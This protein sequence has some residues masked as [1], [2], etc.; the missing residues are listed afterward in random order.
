MAASIETRGKTSTHLSHYIGSGRQIITSEL[1][2][3]RDLLRYATD[4]SLGRGTLDK[5]EKF[6]EGLDQLF[7]ILHCKC[8]IVLCSEYGCNNPEC[9]QKVHIN[10]NCARDQ[11]IPVIELM[12]IKAQKAK[13]GSI[14]IHMIANKDVPETRR[15]EA[16]LQRQ[17]IRSLSEQKRARKLKENARK[18]KE[19]NLVA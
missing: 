11:K 9:F 5:K 7:D 16:K 15:Q 8:P 1:P 19:E 4:V 3:V 12:F 14:S 13:Q 6:T 18:E 2:T 10:C 17:E